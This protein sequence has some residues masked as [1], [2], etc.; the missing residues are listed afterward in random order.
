MVSVAVRADPLFGETEKRTVPLPLPFAPL[1]IEIHV[2]SFVALQPQLA[3]AV[4][5]TVTSPPAAGTD[6]LDGAIE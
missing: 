5:V 2:A 4:T 6:S 1:V 3:P